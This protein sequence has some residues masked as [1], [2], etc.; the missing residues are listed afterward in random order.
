MSTTLYVSNLPLSATTEMLTT[1]FR[2]FGNVL[3]VVLEPEDRRK[4]RGALVEMN[5]SSDAQKAIAGLNLS[6]FDGRLVS[7]YLALSSVS[8][9]PS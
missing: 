7:V 5:T 9:K 3:S 8:K 4:R 6:D 2:K 1:R